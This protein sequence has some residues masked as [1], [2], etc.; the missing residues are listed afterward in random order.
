MHAFPQSQQQRNNSTDRNT[1]ASFYF[2]FF[3]P[4]FVIDVSESWNGYELVERWAT[5]TPY[6]LRWKGDNDVKEAEG[7]KAKKGTAISYQWRMNV[8]LK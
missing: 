2:Y 5:N 1:V 7:K 3:L 8:A 4:L 6:I